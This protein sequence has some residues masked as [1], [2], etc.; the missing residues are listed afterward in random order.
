MLITEKKSLAQRMSEGRLAVVEALRYAMVLAEALR[1]IHDSGRSHGSVTPD[2]LILKGAGLELE[3]AEEATSGNITPYTAPELLLGRAPDARSDIFSFGA[4]LFE[5]VTGHRAFEG[6]GR[7]TVAANIAN[8]PTPTSGSPALDRLVAPCLVKNPAERTS[9]M[10][11]IMMELKLLTVAVR[12]AETA[13]PK[14]ETVD[15]AA[16]RIEMQELEARIEA[17]LASQFQAQERLLSEMQR[18]AAAAVSAIKGELS[19]LGAELAAAHERAAAA[20]P[21]ETLIAEAGERILARVDRGFEAVSEHVAGIEQTIEDIRHH[22]Q[23]F[24]HS[25]SAD[26]AQVDQNFKVQSAAIEAARTA[27][28]QTD[29]LVERVVEALESLQTAVLDAGDTGSDHA[30]FAVN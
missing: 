22:H 25:M 30:S 13:A 15:P 29:D 14:R 1:R 8:A 21:A 19:A 10:Q 23:Q 6:E 16:V 12:R 3:P 20:T 4:I 18:S 27:M 5:M 24:E 17:R 2:H 11:K 28:A 26:L 9:R 7:A